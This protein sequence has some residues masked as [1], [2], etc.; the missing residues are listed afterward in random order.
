MCLVIV[1][2]HDNPNKGSDLNMVRKNPALQPNRAP[3][4]P[5]NY[6]CSLT[7]TE[8]IQEI[9]PDFHLFTYPHGEAGRLFGDRSFVSFNGRVGTV[10]YAY[11][12]F[13][14]KKNV[15]LSS[16]NKDDL[17]RLRLIQPK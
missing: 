4:T 9:Y 14:D 11:C 10:I 5:V 16:T 2:K 8:A 15:P 13:K 17:L 7:L 1:S 12:D 3:I 6:I